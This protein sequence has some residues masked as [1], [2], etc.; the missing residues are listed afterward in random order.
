MKE[1]KKLHGV[2]DATVEI[3]AG[4]RTLVFAAGLAHAERLCE[5]IN[6]KEP[7]EAIFIH[8]KTPLEERR[9]LVKGFRGG[10]YTYMINVQVATEGFDVPGIELIAI[11]RPTC[12]RALYAQMVGR[13]TR[14]AEALVP[15]L[16]YWDWPQYRRVAIEHSSKPHLE[17]LD[18]I[19]QS[20]K[21]KLIHVGDILAGDYSD[22]VVM[23]AE[24]NAQKKQ[25]QDGLPADMI[26][27]LRLA[28]QEL[29][30][31]QR[32][33]RRRIVAKASWK[34]RD[35]DPFDVLDVQRKREKGW[36]TG[37]P[38]TERQ[39]MVLRKAGMDR[40]ETLS[41]TEASQMIDQIITRSQEGL[42]TY[43]Q[44]RLLARYGYDQNVTFEEAGA[45][46]TKLADNNWKALA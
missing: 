5:I 3:A 25:E 16:N 2:A 41:F 17:V 21:H 23:R 38:A 33:H 30:K 24:H 43:K 14:P 18:F 11:A 46:I 26:E 9:S 22:D 19:G 7:G 27:Q 36:H 10:R 29:T 31:E 20:G 8:G 1:E 42:C 39:R 45:V 12:S 15:E 40:A 34:T 37:R 6:R 32:L 44:A 4:R 28:E 13:G 35:I